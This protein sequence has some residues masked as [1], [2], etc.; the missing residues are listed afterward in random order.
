[1][2]EWTISVIPTDKILSSA[3][4][5]ALTLACVTNRD[6]SEF[7]LELVLREIRKRTPVFPVLDTLF[8]ECVRLT[9]LRAYDIFGVI[10][11]TVGGKVVIEFPTLQ[12]PEVAARVVRQVEQGLRGEQSSLMYLDLLLRASDQDVESLIIA[13]FDLHSALLLDRAAFSLTK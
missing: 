1:M 8:G 6:F 2:T 9:A 11:L 7:G 10:P 3:E 13:L 5:R 12:T 4:L